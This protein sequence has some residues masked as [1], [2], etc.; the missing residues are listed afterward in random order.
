[1]KSACQ[2][3]LR[4]AEGTG[5]LI[6]HYLCSSF[7]KQSCRAIYDHHIIVFQQVIV[8]L[9]QLNG[10]EQA[11]IFFQRL[12]GNERLQRNRSKERRTA[13]AGEQAD[14]RGT[15]LQD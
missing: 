3:K 10:V 15:G 1:M 6:R 11:V 8:I 12:L 9:I 4:H 13:N 7:Q 2:K 14:G 5:S